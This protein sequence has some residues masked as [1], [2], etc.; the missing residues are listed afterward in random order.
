MHSNKKNTVE[1]QQNNWWL[2]PPWSRIIGDFI[3]SIVLTC[4]FRLFN[5]ECFPALLEQRACT[6]FT[7]LSTN[8]LCNYYPNYFRRRK[9]L[10]RHSRFMCPDKFTSTLGINGT[11]MSRVSWMQGDVVQLS[12]GTEILSSGPSVFSQRI[13][14]LEAMIQKGRGREKWKC[15]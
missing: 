4:I 6:L 10:A 13:K 5:N 2:L 11:Q 14:L 1:R 3:F 15:F 9:I 12:L 8:H 7:F